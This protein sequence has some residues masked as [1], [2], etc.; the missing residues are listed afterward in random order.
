MPRNTVKIESIPIDDATTPPT[1][2]DGAE[3]PESQPAD[4]DAA[5]RAAIKA[6]LDAGDFDRVKA[7]VAVLEASPKAAPVVPIRGL[8]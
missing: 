8:R 2:S 4:P 7:L 6:A 1:V 5:L 3:R